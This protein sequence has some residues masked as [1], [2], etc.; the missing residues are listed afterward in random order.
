MFGAFTV[1]VEKRW[2]AAD[3]GNGHWHQF[4][5][6]EFEVDAAGNWRASRPDITHADGFLQGP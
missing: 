1:N 5:R 4:Y 6:G 3:I 2:Y